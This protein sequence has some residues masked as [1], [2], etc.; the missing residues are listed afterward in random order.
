MTGTTWYGPA[1]TWPSNP[2][3]AAWIAFWRNLDTAI[4]D[5]L[6]MVILGDDFWGTFTTGPL[7]DH[8]S[9]TVSHD[10]EVVQDGSDRPARRTPART[11]RWATSARSRGKAGPCSRTPDGSFSAPSRDRSGS[12]ER[13]SGPTV[14]TSFGSSQRNP[15]SRD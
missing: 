1:V 9:I 6:G 12:P 3:N 2:Q 10:H 4:G 8:V 13:A 5:R 11:A 14:K 15:A 7:G